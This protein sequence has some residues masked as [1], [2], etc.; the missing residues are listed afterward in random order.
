MTR[1]FFVGVVVL[2]AAATSV[3]TQGSPTTSSLE[4]VWKITES[5]TTGANAEHIANPQPGLLIF[6]RG[7]YSWVSV[8][9]AAPRAAFQDAKDPNKLTDAEKIARYAQWSEFTGHSGTYAV[10]GTTLTRRPIAAKNVSVMTGP[11]QVAEIK[12]EGNTLSLTTKSAAGQPVSETRLKLA[13]V[14]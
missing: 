14:Q 2:V 1:G 13:R 4:G 7:Y 10:N 5:V 9:S 6:S 11:P 12:V 3:F 8:D